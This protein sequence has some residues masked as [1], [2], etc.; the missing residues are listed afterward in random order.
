MGSE[1]W[2]RTALAKDRGNFW[3]KSLDE[4]LFGASP[5][6]RARHE[7]FQLAGSA[8]DSFEQI[9]RLHTATYPSARRPVARRPTPADRSAL[10][11]DYEREAVRGTRFWKRVE[12]RTARSEAAL[13]SE[14]A[15]DAADK[16]ARAGRKARQAELDRDWEA[17]L[18]HDRSAVLR[19]LAGAFKI[20]PY[21]SRAFG[22]TDDEALVFVEFD[23]LSVPFEE[24][25]FTPTGKL[26]VRKLTKTARNNLYCEG[27]AAITINA[28]QRSLAAS[29][30]AR[31]ATA[32]TLRYGS[33]DPVAWLR[34]PCD[35]DDDSGLLALCTG[36]DG[37]SA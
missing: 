2:W 12:R 19:A 33:A 17:L 5:A 30:G 37:G 24:P 26:T 10:R 8:S 31:Y 21:R 28:V 25:S 16:R 1:G 36:S 4:S 15:A 29:P 20:A 11:R 9:T 35:A 23:D 7:R 6:K 3:S 22:A 34:L 18:R 27:V 13:R 32:V 14:Q